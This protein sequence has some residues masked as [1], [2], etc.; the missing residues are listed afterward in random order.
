MPPTQPTADADIAPAP[1]S[2]PRC[3]GASA[4]SASVSSSGRTRSSPP[5]ATRSPAIAWRTPT[6]SSVPRGTGKTS[7]ARI[8]A[9][10]INCTNLGADG[11]PCDTCPACVSIRE[12]RALDVIEI[13]AASHG[14]VEDAR[15]L[16]MRR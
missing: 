14:A 12:G 8:L 7:T 13:D 3:I 10:A 11:E 9:K 4:P 5:S 2:T 15:D 16:V 6:S 1:V